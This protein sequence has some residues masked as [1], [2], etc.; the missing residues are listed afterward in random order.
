MGPHPAV[1]AIRLAVRRVLNDLL[2]EYHH[3]LAEQPAG[4]PPRA[5][6]LERVGRATRA[7]RARQIRARAGSGAP[8]QVPAPSEAPAPHTEGPLVLVACSGGADS[9]ALASALAF[10]APRL[11]IRAGGI[12]VDHGLQYGSDAR[13]ADVVARLTAL[14][15]DPVESAAVRVAA[16]SDRTAHGAPYAGGARRVGPEAAARDARYAALDEAAERHGAAAVLL[17]HTRDDQAETV[18]LGLARGSG[19]RSLS[20]MAAVSGDSGRYR[21]PFLQLDR[22]TARTACLAQSLPVWDDPHNADPAYT[23]SRLRHEGL[24]ALEKALGKGVVEA[25]AR[26]AQLS[27]DDA[28]ALDA[29]AAREEAAVRDEA[30]ELDCARL[31]ALPAAVRRRILRRA[32]VAAGAPGGSLFA[33][34]VE[35]VDRL[36]TGWRGQRAINLPGKVEARRQGG[37]LVLRQG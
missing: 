3:P 2:T 34:H 9:M 28:D 32:L 8:A 19:I 21:R 13:A 5:E 15:L 6:L 12:T 29:W 11:G 30:G 37:R 31:H 22:Q 17:G 4:R 36:I 1:A 10:E 16:A 23:R 20:G 25:L 18:L 33:R 7:G 35:E 26:T 27:R 14:G 24:P